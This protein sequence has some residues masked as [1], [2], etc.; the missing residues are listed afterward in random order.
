M[1]SDL[2]I[3]ES[4]IAFL[5]IVGWSMVL[6]LYDF[7]MFKTGLYKRILSK[8]KP[9]TPKKYRAFKALLILL[10][11]IA[12]LICLSSFVTSGFLTGEW[13]F[14]LYV[15]GCPAVLT[16]PSW[17]I[18]RHIGQIQIRKMNKD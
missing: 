3:K 7:I 13:E 18:L 11:P 8:A 16:F 5:I 9:M 6:F 17:L 14:F 4:R 1:I 10:M 2:P 12:P 15:W